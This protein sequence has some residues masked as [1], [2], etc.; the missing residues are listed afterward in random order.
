[1]TELA[2][3]KLG[4]HPAKH[5]FGLPLVSSYTRHLP[6]PPPATNYGIK[7]R[8]DAMFLNDTLGCCTVSAIGHAVEVWTANAQAAEV[9]LPD[10]EIRRVYGA[11]SG[12]NGD[13]QTDN[14][15]ACADVLRYWYDNP[16]DGHK[17][18]AFAS[19]RPGNHDDIKNAVYR[20]GSCYIGIQ[21]PLTAQDQDGPW[22]VV[23]G[24]NMT[25]NAAPGSWG[26]HCVAIDAY[27]D[28]SGLT[29]RTWSMEKKMTWA[30]WDAYCDEAFALLG[31]DWI[32][33]DGRSPDE[34]DISQL[35]D[36]MNT[37]RGVRMK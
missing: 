18:N 33:A 21:L 29:C 9:T 28:D 27:D 31:Q 25:G 10:S 6:P 8:T 7:A 5:M 23:G 17:L 24:G 36:D 26:G 20:F 4:K 16:I 11:V 30:F 2:K 34:I 1:M 37:F 14:G 35:M 19:V 22:D 32:E 15:A 12:Y 13:P 3:M